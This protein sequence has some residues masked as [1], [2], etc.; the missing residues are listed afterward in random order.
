VSSPGARFLAFTA[1]T[2]IG[3][4][5]DGTKYSFGIEPRRNFASGLVI[6]GFYQ[7][8][9]LD[10]NSRDQMENI[11]I[12]RLKLLYMYDIKWSVSGFIQ[13]NNLDNI[14]LG[15]FRLRYNPK[16]GTDIYLVYNED[17]NSNKSDFTPILPL[18]NERLILLKATYTFQ[19]K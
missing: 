19:S 17:F 18:S 8:N 7:Y 1:Q 15:N 10:F 9:H 11:H 6:S 5:Y 13:Y 16:E 2:D 12:T 3:S 14:V 4:F